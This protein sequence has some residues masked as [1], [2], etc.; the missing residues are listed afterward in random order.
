MAA[1]RAEVEAVAVAVQGPPGQA[2]H[3]QWAAE[4]EHDRQLARRAA[5]PALV[6]ALVAHDRDRDREPVVRDRGR[7]RVA[8]DRD[9]VRAGQAETLPGAA[10]PRPAN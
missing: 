2:G 8:R 7:A 3:L 10:V 1:A 9:R 6:R 5:R 4:A